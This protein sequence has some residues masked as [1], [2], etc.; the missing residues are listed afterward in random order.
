MEN[1]I[2]AAVRSAAQ[3][4][5]QAAVVIISGGGQP[6]RVQT[7]AAVASAPGVEPSQQIIALQEHLTQASR[8]RDS[9][10][11]QNEQLSQQFREAQARIA[12]LEQ[13][14]PAPGSASAQP[15]EVIDYDS[16]PIEPL[17]LPEKVAKVCE[18]NDVKTIGQ[19]REFFSKLAEHKVSQ[20]DRIAAAE[21]LMG[22]IPSNNA[23]TLSAA[24]TPGPNTSIL[25]GD[26]PAGHVDRGWKDRL[27]VARFKEDKAKILLDGLSAAYAE[28]AAL[29]PGLPDQGAA[30]FWDGALAALFGVGP[31]NREAAITKMAAY[32][33]QKVVH[34]ITDSQVAA[35]LYALGFDPKVHRTV[36]AALE[37]AGLAHLSEAVPA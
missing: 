6:Q 33:G 9:A 3:S 17:N 1:L 13:S 2:D 7:P 8:A 14:H 24:V 15:A 12:E 22:R 5:M 19:L 37:G 10:L 11:R 29:V 20:K 31:E 23:A 25:A 30:N 27:K 34:D 21:A 35:V 26:V 32:I 28:V 16:M 36:D 4:G 18:K